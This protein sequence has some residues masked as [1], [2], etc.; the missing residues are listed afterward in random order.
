MKS[1]LSILATCLL[2]F[3][4]MQKAYCQTFSVKCN[5]DRSRYMVQDILKK[6]NTKLA[7]DIAEADYIVECKITVPQDFKAKYKGC[8]I[9]Y[10]RNGTEISRTVE[11]K[12]NACAVNGFNAAADIFQVLAEEHM[13][14]LINKI[15]NR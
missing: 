13:P 10:D 6:L 1:S 15:T 14:E 4:F 2:F 11:I 3:I 8:I 5:D 7:R 9:I 12:R